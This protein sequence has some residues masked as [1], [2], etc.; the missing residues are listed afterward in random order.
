MGEQLGDLLEVGLG[1]FGFARDFQIDQEH[2]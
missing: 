1:F 2:H